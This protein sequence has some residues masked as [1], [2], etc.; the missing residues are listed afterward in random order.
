MWQRRALA[1]IPTV[2]WR[3]GHGYT[4]VIAE[5]ITGS[6]L[7]WRLSV[8]ALL[9]DAPFSIFTGWRRSF[10]LLG[11]ESVILSEKNGNW[12]CTVNGSTPP[13]QFSGEDAVQSSGIVAPVQALNLMVRSNI[14]SEQP[15][16]ILLKKAAFTFLDM[17][18]SQIFLIPSNGAWN[19]CEGQSNVSM[20][21]GEIWSNS[22]PISSRIF[23]TQEKPKNSLFFVKI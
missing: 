6:G 22:D 23:L 21:P 2:Q 19:L 16:L 18:E 14:A 3:N 7:Q 11:Q 9:K 17:G 20:V 8:A 10:A 1:D 15:R 13:F 5:G 4:K 12:S